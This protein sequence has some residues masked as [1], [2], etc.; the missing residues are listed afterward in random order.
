M[1]EAV[2]LAKAK[3]YEPIKL[4]GTES[5]LYSLMLI[6]PL[7]WQSLSLVLGW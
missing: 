3:G 7:F 1:E 6:D 2:N 4:Y 5:E